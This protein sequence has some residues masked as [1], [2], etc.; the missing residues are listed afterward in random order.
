M[1]ITMLTASGLEGNL[2]KSMHRSTAEKY[3]T[4]ST[5]PRATIV[6]IRKR[7]MRMLLVLVEPVD[8]LLVGGSPATMW[9]DIPSVCSSTCFVRKN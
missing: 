2:K 3:R 5:T 8:K 6:L 1:G 4:I 9:Q 7:L